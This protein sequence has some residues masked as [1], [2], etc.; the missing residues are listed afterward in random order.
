MNRRLKKFTFFEIFF[1]FRDA[2]RNS[3]YIWRASYGG[4]AEWLKAHAWKACLPNRNEGSN[5]SPSSK[6]MKAF[7]ACIYKIRFHL[8]HPLKSVLHKPFQNHCYCLKTTLYFL[9]FPL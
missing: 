7:S 1:V 2:F 9:R 5:P 8:F 6:T 3:L 4:M